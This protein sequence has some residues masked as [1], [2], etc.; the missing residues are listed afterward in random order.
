MTFP[1][2]IRRALLGGALLALAGHATAGPNSY[3]ELGPDGGRTTQ[4]LFDQLVDDRLYLFGQKVGVHRSDD[5]GATWQPINP[6]LPQIASTSISGLAVSTVDGTVY[7]A[8]N[9]NVVA[10]SPDAGQTWIAS[11]SE[12]GFGV[13]TVF[14]DPVN[15]DIVYATAGALV[16]KSI[17]GGDTWA[18]VTGTLGFTV[19]DEIAIDPSNSDRILVTGWE[20]VARSTDG[21]AMWETLSNGLPAPDSNGWIFANVLGIDPIDPDVAYAFVSNDGVYKT[22]DFGD[23]WSKVSV[24]LPN[25]FFTRLIFDPANTDT[26]IVGTGNND[27][28]VS[29]DGGATWSD[30]IN[31][32]LGDYTINDVAL[33]PDNSI[34]LFAASSARGVYVTD[35]GAFS[36][37]E[38][39]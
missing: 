33:D 16:Y 4:V 24:N 38:T 10:R 39:S 26:L 20:G 15:A 8:D 28:I 9:S 13:T 32:G 7:V 21:G 36:W 25:D 35:D 6:D 5:D 12:L 30:L 34:R 18:N 14:T 29:F 31:F 23:S 3:T 17:N 2:G 37:Q 11:D 19:V 1:T 27:V 22:L